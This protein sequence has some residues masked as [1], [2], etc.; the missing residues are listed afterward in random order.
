MK[1]S[2]LE[3]YTRDWMTN[4]ELRMCS[5]SSR[6]LSL[7][8]L[9]LMHESGRRGFLQHVSGDPVTAAQLAQL[10]GCA[11]SVV[12][13]LLQELK[14]A[15]VFSCTGDG[16]IYS[17]RM[18]RDE[19]FRR[20]ASE[21][22]KRG[23][24][25][26]LKG[27]PKGGA[28]GAPKGRLTPSSSCS[29][30]LSSNSSFNSSSDHSFPPIPPELNTPA[31]VDLWTQWQSLRREQHRPVTPTAARGQL[32]KLANW[33]VVRAV[34]AIRHSISNG[35][36]GIFEPKENNNGKSISNVRSTVEDF[37]KCKRETEY[38]EGDL[39]LPIAGG[40]PEAAI[41]RGSVG[42]GKDPS[43]ASD[44][45]EGAA[46]LPQKHGGGDSEDRQ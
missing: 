35:W 38:D 11:T 6:G 10:T 13:G 15:G 37:R 16:M 44:E 2:A 36:Q 12:E 25:P 28:K 26:T 3:I 19:E 45:H 18:V 4:P 23:G 40:T 30:S 20:A 29:S 27:L 1:S 41:A 32:A 7:D 33:G 21:S 43:P 42:S 34:N 9:C 24:N 14:S 22:G 39:K 5:L 46:G 31:F 17:P 8:M